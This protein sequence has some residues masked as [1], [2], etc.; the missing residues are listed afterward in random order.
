MAGVER[1]VP[2]SDDNDHK[3]WLS[4][5]LI[6]FIQLRSGISSHTLALLGIPVHSLVFPCMSWWP[7]L[8]LDLASLSFHRVVK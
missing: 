7:E 2:S 4:S 1:A 5:L 3:V 6:P 8:S